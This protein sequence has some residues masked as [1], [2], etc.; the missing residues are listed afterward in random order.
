VRFFSTPHQL[1]Y[2]ATFAKDK[3]NMMKFYSAALNDQISRIEL[4][5]PRGQKLTFERGEFFFREL[6]QDSTYYGDIRTSF[7]VVLGAFE[8]TFNS[9]RGMDVSADCTRLIGDGPGESAVM[10]I[11]FDADAVELHRLELEV[12]D[13]KAKVQKSE[14]DIAKLKAKKK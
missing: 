5:M 12:K 8:M 14:D 1:A 11:Y 9:R 13:L 10:N 4:C 2:F 3:E 6:K 7:T